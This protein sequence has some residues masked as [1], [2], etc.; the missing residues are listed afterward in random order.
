MRTQKSGPKKAKEVITEKNCDHGCG[1]QAKFLNLSGK[2]LCSSTTQQCPSVKARN[3][4]GGLKSYSSGK[5]LSA[6]KVYENLPQEVKDS[7]AWS[8]GLTKDVDDR[9]SRPQFIGK[10]F[11]ASLTGHT[12][13]T[14]AL[15]SSLRTEYLKKSENRKNLGRHKKSWMEETFE[16]Y[17]INN[18][19]EDWESEVHFWSES[20]RKNFYPDFLFR[21]QMLIIELDGTQHRK[22]VESDS[23]RDEWFSSI[24]YKVIRIPVEEFKRR[25]FSGEGFLDL[26]GR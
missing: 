1:Q 12:P 20:L 19:I 3:S 15:L 7:M 11:G 10:R 25:F 4:T 17:L 2:Y 8:R 24:G 22:T 16:K 21:N 6:D 9:V 13:E 14:K 26:L 5:R 23:I 18:N